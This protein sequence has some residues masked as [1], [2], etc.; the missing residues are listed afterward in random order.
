MFVKKDLNL[1]FGSDWA[2]TLTS[3]QALHLRMSQKVMHEW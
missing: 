3:M 1:D 2:I